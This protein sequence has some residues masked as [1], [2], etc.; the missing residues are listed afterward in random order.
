MSGEARGIQ[1]TLQRRRQPQ[2]VTRK[3]AGSYP[4]DL[5]N[6]L[7]QGSLNEEPKVSP[8]DIAS[9]PAEQPVVTRPEHASSTD[10]NTASQVS[11]IGQNTTPEAS[12]QPEDGNED[13]QQ[14]EIPTAAVLLEYLQP[15]L[16]TG[17]G[18]TELRRKM[19]HEKG[20]AWTAL[21]NEILDTILRLR[22]TRTPNQK[23]YEDMQKT[24]G[25]QLVV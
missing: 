15:I 23:I 19:G 5:V 22:N 8:E 13:T 2:L 6:Y 17:I 16:K 7:L 11:S 4:T 1:V 12:S 21:F 10:Q 9:L 25:I 24:Y 18:V 14:D 3:Q 20:K